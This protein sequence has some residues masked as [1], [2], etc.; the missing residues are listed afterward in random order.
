MQ[1]CDFNFY[2]Q[3]FLGDIIKDERNFNK[4]SKEA[5]MVINQYTY[6]KARDLTELS[7]D[8]ATSIKECC[9]SLT[10]LLYSYSKTSKKKSESCEGWSVTYSDSNTSIE[11][12]AEIRQLIDR[13][14]DWTD[15]LCCWV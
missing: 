4:L 10:E 13:Y 8:V 9:C 6:S 2:N 3:T 14:L 15:L 12:S 7:E 1:F 5:S 11:H